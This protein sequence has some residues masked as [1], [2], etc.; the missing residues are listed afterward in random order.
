MGLW[1][2]QPLRDHGEQWHAFPTRD[3][4]RGPPADAGFSVLQA[5]VASRPAA[6]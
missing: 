2:V 6:E 3:I 1:M 5:S 4:L